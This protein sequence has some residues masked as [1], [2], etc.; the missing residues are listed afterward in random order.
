MENDTS[1][2]NIMPRQLAKS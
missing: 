1:K 2:N